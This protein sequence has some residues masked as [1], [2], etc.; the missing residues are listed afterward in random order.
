MEKHQ[1]ILI[2][3]LGYAE[4][5]D[6][7]QDGRIVSLGDILRTTPILHEYKENH[8]TW[9]TSEKAK[10]LLTDNLYIDRLMTLDLIN[11]L[12]L[13]SEEF[14]KIIN[15][16]KVPGI[17]ALSDKIRARKVR[18]GFTFN[19]QTGEAEALDKAYEVIAVSFNPEYKKKNQRTFQELL[20]E[21]LGEKF[22]GEEYVLG[23]NPKTKEEYDIGLNTQVGGKWPTKAWETKNWDGLESLL[24]KEGLKV[25]RQDRQDTKVLNDLHSYIDWIN[26]SKIIVSSDSLGL[27]LGLAMKKYILGLFG[28]TSDKEIYFYNRGKAIMPSDIQECFPC[29]EPKCEKGLDSCINLITPEK[30]F[31]EIKGYLK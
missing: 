18:Y 7:E 26:S 17:C 1:K 12:Q 22:K 16:E 8:V 11:S 13:E 21:M 3:K 23:Y 14:D 2:F 20:F 27:H 4:I 6:K 24:I 25:T 28:P 10:P 5:L 19:T 30:V 9:V 29:F 31:H 15:L